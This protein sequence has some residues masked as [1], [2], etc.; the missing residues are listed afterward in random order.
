MNAKYVPPEYNSSGFNCPHCGA[1]SEQTWWAIQCLNPN[2]GRRDIEDLKASY[3]RRCSQYSLWKGNRIIHPGV[4]IAPLPADDMPE[5]IKQD[6]LEAREI[7]AVSPRGAAALLR[8]ALEKLLKHLGETGKDINEDI[9]SL[10]KKGLPPGIQE[11]L[12]AVRVIGN[13][14]VHP[15]TLDLRDDID[16]AQSLFNLLNW[17]VEDRISK[18]KEINR[19]YDLL[20]E[21]KRLAI[22]KRD[23]TLPT[24]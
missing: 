6:Y 23:G 20:P 21:S 22:Q 4:S 18:F 17:F 7:V 2:G 16:T 9:A 19:I 24:T 1:F 3:C 13:E 12:D 11:I 10:V 14:A 15:G 8:L 5:E